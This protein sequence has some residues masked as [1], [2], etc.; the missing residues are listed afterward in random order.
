[1]RKYQLLLCFLLTF[2]FLILP[3]QS[4]FAASEPHQKVFDY[5]GLLTKKEIKE[6]ESV[7]NKYS[8]K[9]KIDFIFITTKDADGKD[10]RKY[11][12]DMYDDEG[13][14]YDKKHGNTAILAIEM[15]GRDVDLL[16]FYKAEKHL[17]NDRLTQIRERITPSLSSGNYKEAFQQ[18]IEIAD[19]YMDYKPGVD[20][21]NILFKWWFQIAVSLGIAGL[22]VGKM[23]VNSGGKV[24]TTAA[25][26]RDI[27]HTKIRRKRDRYIRKTVTKRKKP[28]DDSSSGSSGGGG[29]TR[30]GHSHSGSRGKF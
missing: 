4:V 21:E 23:V 20:P 24:T 27:N 7:S 13:F 2:L 14:G 22:V 11:V 16:G 28:S 9:R 8:K 26:Y 29:V 15:E 1:M 10:I 18:F 12:Q 6:L 19:R 17:D 30:G 3:L 5:A 25:T